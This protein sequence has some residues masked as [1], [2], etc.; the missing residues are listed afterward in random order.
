MFEEKVKTT[1]GQAEELFFSAK[2]E[3]SRPNRD[4]VPY[5][6]CRSAYKA[7]HKYLTG[8][9]LSHGMDIHASTSLEIL[10]DKCQEIDSKFNNLNLKPLY[11]TKVNEDVWLDMV[12]VNKYIELASETRKLVAQE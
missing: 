4:L 10:L 9:L 5:M 11:S 1:L 2:K 7:I 3:L 8:F 6:V 12:T